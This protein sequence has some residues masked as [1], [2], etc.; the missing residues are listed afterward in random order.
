MDD[1]EKTTADRRASAAL[2]NL[3]IVAIAAV[4]FMFLAGYGSEREFEIG[5][6]FFIVS[7]VPCLFLGFRNAVRGMGWMEDERGKPAGSRDFT[8]LACA[9]VVGIGLAIAGLL[10]F[11][12]IFGAPA[13]FAAY[14]SVVFVVFYVAPLLYGMWYTFRSLADDIRRHDRRILWGTLYLYALLA[15]PVLIFAWSFIDSV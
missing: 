3:S 2:W 11:E 14:G 10:L 12:S 15:A 6:V 4:V 9:A 7:G 5:V 13:R 1:N 8:P